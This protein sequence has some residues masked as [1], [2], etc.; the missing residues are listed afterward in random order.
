M[1]KIDW[2]F[3]YIN[4][5]VDGMIECEGGVK[6]W[7]KMNDDGEYDIYRL[8]KEYVDELEDEHR[9]YCEEMSIPLKYGDIFVIPEKRGLDFMNIK[10]FRF[11]KACGVI[12]GEKVCTIKRSDILNF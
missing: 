12:L 6:S 10:F 2:V 7:F 9:R 5:P 4:V 11:E 8:D 3:T 1:Y